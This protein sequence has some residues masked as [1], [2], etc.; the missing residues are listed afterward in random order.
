MK[1]R[2]YQAAK[3][4]DRK[5]GQSPYARYGKVPYKYPFPTGKEYR[6]ARERGEIKG[7]EQ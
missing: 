4:R 1:R 6:E 3:R 2:S 7:I 5:T